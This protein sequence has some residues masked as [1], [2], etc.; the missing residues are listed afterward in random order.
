MGKHIVASIS[1]VGALITV[2]LGATELL[3]PPLA[4]MKRLE[5]RARCASFEVP[6]GMVDKVLV[7]FADTVPWMREIPSRP[8]PERS[9]D[10]RFKKVDEELRRL[11]DEHRA[12]LKGEASTIKRA[13]T[14]F[15]NEY[16]SVLAGIDSVYQIAVENSGDVR[17]MAV[18]VEIPGAAF[19][20][21][22]RR[23]VEPT[24]DSSDEMLM[25]G[26]LQQGEKVAI[27]AW[28]KASRCASLEPGA[29]AGQAARVRIWHETG[30]TARVS[31]AGDVA[32]IKTTPVSTAERVQAWL[33]PL[34]TWLSML[35]TLLALVVGLVLGRDQGVK[36]TLAAARA[37]ASPPVPDP[38]PA[39]TPTV[40]V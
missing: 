14:A 37:A 4:E 36:A 11:D 8:Q 19:T 33:P 16:P 30:Q 40:E 29:A 2:I 1:V 7:P 25:L 20:Q 38:E 24:F 3:A 28:S 27:T 22:K 13:R 35:S 5:A 32:V 34:G 10:P 15:S 12:W 23:G 26:E 18:R 39:L 31:M 21:V 6:A 17:L 9:S